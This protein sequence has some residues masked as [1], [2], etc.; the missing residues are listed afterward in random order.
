MGKKM[1][2]GSGALF[3]GLKIERKRKKRERACFFFVSLILGLFPSSPRLSNHPSS[4]KRSLSYFSVP[5]RVD[6]KKNK[7]KQRK[8]KGKWTHTQTKF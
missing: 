6:I 4:K 1:Q 5:S 2:S 7:A 8:G 3:K